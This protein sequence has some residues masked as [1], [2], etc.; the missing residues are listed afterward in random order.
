MSFYYVCVCTKN[1]PRL[2]EPVV[3][4][5]EDSWIASNTDAPD[6][7]VGWLQPIS[8]VILDD[9]DVTRYIIVHENKTQ[10]T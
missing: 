6:W 7:L 1:E 4:D 9:L 10:L 3:E 5:V 8:C 2:R